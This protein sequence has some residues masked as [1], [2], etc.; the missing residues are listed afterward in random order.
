M[1]HSDVSD[2]TE[3]TNPLFPVSLQESVLL[4]GE[5]EGEAF[6]TEVTLLEHPRVM[7]WAGQR[8]EV[9]VSQYVAYLDGRIEEVAY[10]LYAQADGGSVW[11][12]GE[13]V[14]NFTDGAI[15]DTHGTWLAGIDGPAAMIMPQ[16]T[17]VALKRS[18][19]P[20]GSVLSSS[21]VMSTIEKRK[22]L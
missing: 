8:V 15:T 13:D 19:T 14:F 5:V 6:R 12:F 2:P 4:L 1:C 20:T 17:M 9:L 11:Y 3:I 10:D 18:L 22:S 21:D 16:S 7:T